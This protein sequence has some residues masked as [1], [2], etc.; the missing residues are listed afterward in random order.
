M[1]DKKRKW[2]YRIVDRFVLNE[3]VDL[4]PMLDKS[5]KAYANRSENYWQLTQQRVDAAIGNWFGVDKDGNTTSFLRW[6]A[7]ASWHFPPPTRTWLS[8]K[9]K[10]EANNFY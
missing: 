9:S 6:V 1:A 5:V 8:N 7:G 2:H 4:R 10:R 3:A